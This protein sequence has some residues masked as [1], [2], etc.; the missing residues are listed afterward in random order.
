[1]LFAA[2]KEESQDV[3]SLD[4]GYPQDVNLQ[5]N[6]WLQ[7]LPPTAVAAE[8]G[9]YLLNITRAKDIIRV[10]P[11][12]QFRKECV[13]LFYSCIQVTDLLLCTLA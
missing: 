2:L 7:Q 1:M 5:C 4:I 10:L 6:S 13:R 8:L 11:K 12:M 3:D 9:N